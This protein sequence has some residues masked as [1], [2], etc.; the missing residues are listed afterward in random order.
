MVNT[1]FP[2]PSTCFYVIQNTW[3]RFD[4]YGVSVLNTCSVPIMFFLVKVSIYRVETWQGDGPYGSHHGG[5]LPMHAKHFGNRPEPLNDGILA[6]KR[7]EVCGFGDRADLDWWFKGFKYDLYRAGFN[8]ARYAVP[9]NL[10]RYGGRQLVFER[11][12]YLPVE[13]SPVIR[14]GLIKK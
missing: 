11:E 6:L 7:G 12:D 8:I 4:Y 14:N 10:I 3:S 5:L 2:N 13:R 9:G 1:R